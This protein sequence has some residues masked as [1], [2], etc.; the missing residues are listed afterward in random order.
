MVLI[1]TTKSLV[2]SLTKVPAQVMS[3][4]TI[5]YMHPEYVT[6]LMMGEEILIKMKKFW[7]GIGESLNKGS[8]SIKGGFLILWRVKTSDFKF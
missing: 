1:D 6:P 8:W 2:L 3:A 5:F 7:E 4:K